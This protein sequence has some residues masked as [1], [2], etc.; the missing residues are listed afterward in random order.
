MNKQ[1]PSV[2]RIFTMIAFAG[3]C[4]GLLL[5]LWISFGGATPFA[6]Q[7]YLLK[8]EFPSAVELATQADVRISGVSVGKV[9]SVSLDQHTGLTKVVMRLDSRYAPRPADTRAILRAKTLLGET[10]LELTTGSQ[11]G[12]KLIDGATIPA[13][14]IDA[15]VQLDQILSTFD[16]KTRHAFQVWQQQYGVALTDRGQQLNEAIAEL[17]PF[18]TNV[19]RVL[20]VLNHDSAATTT[21][22]RDT[23]AVFSSL[24]RSPAELQGFIRNSNATFAATAARDTALAN[25]VRAFPSFL[26]QTRTTVNQLGSFARLA[27]PLIDELRPGAAQ[28]SPALKELVIVAPELRNLMVYTGPLVK[29]AHRGIPALERFLSVS[30]PFLGRLRKYLGG[31]VPV[32][33][34]IN[35]FRTEIA[36]FFANGTATTQGIQTSAAGVTRHNVR[37]SNPVNPEVLTPYDGRL[38]SNRGNPYMDPMGYLKL[39]GG[40]DVFAGYICTNRPQPKIGK[41]ISKQTRKVLRNVYYT[42]KPGG[43][44]VQGANCTQPQTPLGRVTTGQ[45]QVF[46][47]LTQLP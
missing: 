6:G 43:P 33:D 19:Q 42:S 18:A 7:G 21:L 29:A 20:S 39:L 17:F 26:V 28:L 13:K 27:K 25:T 37:I 32:I 2:G 24:S 46:P 41:S 44:P 9:I 16:K 11:H 23:G 1:A 31:L 47:H 35:T 4:V 12:R 8:A 14:N 5:F 45:N 30:V 3:S 34:Y 40:L 10:Y 22:L 38:Y 36:G 15:T